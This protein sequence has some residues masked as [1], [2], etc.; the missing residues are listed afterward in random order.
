MHLHLTSVR[1]L[2]FSPAA[3]RLLLHSVAAGVLAITLPGCIGGSAR[4]LYY[5]ARAIEAPSFEGDGSVIVSRDRR[6]ELREALLHT[7]RLRLADAD[8]EK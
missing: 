7:S 6:D 5:G 8:S 1:A 3:A 2:S 4:E